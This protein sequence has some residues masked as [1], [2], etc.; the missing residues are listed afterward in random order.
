[1]A[2]L[3]SGNV[4]SWNIR[5]LNSEPKQLALRNAIVTSGCAI[6]CLQETKKTS[7]DLAFI[8]TC[9]PRQFD[10]FAFV[11]S[12]GASGGTVTI[13]KS[14][15]FTGAV[16]FS[17]HFALVTQFISTQSQQSWTLASIYGPC[18][19]DDRVTY[20][21]WLYDLDIPASQDW[22]LLGDFNYICAPDNRNKPDGSVSD[23]FTFNDIIRAQNLIELPVKG[24]AY[25]W[26]NMQL[27]PLLEQLDWFFTSLHWTTV[28]P[29]TLVKPLGKPVSDHI[30][31]V[32]S[33]E[34][35]IPCSKVFRF[36]SYWLLHPGF[37][38]IVRASWNKPV[39]S[40]NAAKI[41]CAKFK[42]LTLALKIWSKSI[43]RLTVAID[44]CNQTLAHLDEMENKR[45]LTIPES[46]FRNILKKHILRL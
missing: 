34:T 33:I 24:R 7:F 17:D 10:C 1:M 40:T 38:N 27:D 5:G 25:T 8:K 43:S 15:M 41:L 46:N 45:P 4:L 19:G 16:L 13:W 14:S 23:M 26:S 30:P 37:M 28:F 36:E 2:L 6:V 39:N 11:P 31:C 20:T 3:R 22:L 12:R 42:R 35:C 44:N 9:C 29:K 21:N 18:T 32:V